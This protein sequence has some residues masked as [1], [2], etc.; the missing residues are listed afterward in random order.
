MLP[1]SGICNASACCHRLASSAAAVV[2]YAVGWSVVTCFAVFSRQ[3][4]CRVTI[5]QANPQAVPSVLHNER[6][7]LVM[8]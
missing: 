5:T 7:H 3:C 8:Q 4:I 2:N 6:Q 1:G